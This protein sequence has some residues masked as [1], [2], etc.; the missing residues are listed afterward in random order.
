MAM[1]SDARPNVAIATASRSLA[2]AVV[3]TS[4]TKKVGKAPWNAMNVT[5][6]ASRRAAAMVDITT[7][8]DPP[9]FGLRKNL[10]T[11]QDRCEAEER[12]A[13]STKIVV[14]GFEPSGPADSAATKLV[15]PK[16]KDPDPRR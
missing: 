12:R 11:A 16:I 5:N 15:E 13:P 7:D 9:P 1:S 6:E 14:A 8:R 4:E 2:M 10:E 3:P